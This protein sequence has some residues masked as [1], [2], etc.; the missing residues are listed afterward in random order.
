M[1]HLPIHIHGVYANRAESIT[2]GQ[3]LCLHLRENII[4]GRNLESLVQ[5][6][7]L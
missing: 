2:N 4:V 6:D 7:R 5:R 3:D 1:G